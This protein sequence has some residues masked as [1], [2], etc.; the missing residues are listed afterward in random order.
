[1]YH[2]DVINTARGAIDVS[3]SLTTLRFVMESRNL[4]PP[5]SPLASLLPFVDPVLRP[6]EGFYVCIKWGQRRAEEEGRAQVPAA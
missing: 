4:L 1:M 3:P 2:R 6:R 5:R